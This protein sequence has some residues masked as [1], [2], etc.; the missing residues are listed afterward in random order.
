[1]QIDWS[2]VAS[3]LDITNGHAAR[4]RFSR[5]RAQME[6]TTS[7]P[8]KRAAP[9]STRSKK[10][11]KTEE[12]KRKGLEASSAIESEVPPSPTTPSKVKR[13]PTDSSTLFSPPRAEQQVGN[14]ENQMGAMA[15]HSPI[16]PD[17]QQGQSSVHSLGMHV[18]TNPLHANKDFGSFADI[19]PPQ[20]V[21]FSHQGPNAVAV[22]VEP[23]WDE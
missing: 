12:G 22:K 19:Y 3:Q 7:T 1:M 10:S 14:V 5:F 21:A 17:Q 23:G 15:M 6:G 18:S 9:N 13:E 11:I 16:R 4:M 8:R 20:N 2:S